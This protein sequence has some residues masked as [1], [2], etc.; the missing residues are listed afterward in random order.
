VKLTLTILKILGAAA[1]VALLLW[2]TWLTRLSS[3]PDV[4]LADRPAE[5]SQTQNQTQP[6][7]PA[8]QGNT[9]TVGVYFKDQDCY[10]RMMRAFSPGLEPLP[11]GLTPSRFENYPQGVKTHT[12]LP[13]D[14][15]LR[16]VNIFTRSPNVAGA[17]VGPLLAMLGLA[18]LVFWWWRSQI[19]HAWMALVLFAVS[20]IIAQATLLGRPDHQAL[21]IVALTIALS[22]ELALLNRVQRRPIPPDDQDAEGETLYGLPARL[23]QD[24]E[25]ASPFR[26]HAVLWQITGGL[27]WGLAFWTSL[28]EPLILLIILLVLT[29]AFLREGLTWHV[30]RW[31]L[32][33]FGILLVPALIDALPL[34]P[35]GAGPGQE[36]FANWAKTIPELRSQGLGILFSGFRGSVGALPD[37]VG[38]GIYLAP[39]L[40]LVGWMQRR[41]RLILVTGLLV[42]VLVVLSAIQ[43][44]WA[45]YAALIF[46]LTLPWQMKALPHAWLGAPVFLIPLFWPVATHWEMLF[47]PPPEQKQLLQNHRSEQVMIRRVSNTIAGEVPRDARAAQ[48]ILAPWWMSPSMAYW[49]GVPTVAGSSHQSLPGIADSFRFYLTSDPRE[50]AAILHE[51]RV[52]WVLAEDPQRILPMGMVFF[53]DELPTGP[54]TQRVVGA[55]GAPADPAQPQFTP[56]GQLARFEHSMATL[57]YHRPRQAPGFLV[58]HSDHFFFKL[59]RVDENVLNQYINRPPATKPRGA[60]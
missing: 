20:P 10:S 57:M 47:D 44:R 46:G 21:L 32:L 40:F 16:A 50:A 54:V 53:G 26:R 31:W 24:D 7:P 5:T 34:T 41:E 29:L 14:M 52:R 39:I 2:L 55:E 35:P 59:Y 56:S 3:A 33:G 42:L 51:R 60:R 9:A 36:F 30:R 43:L 13:M 18:W 19:P 15:A 1:G 25:H 22:S 37:W 8:A 48:S 27:A 11:P 6:Q 38:W 23:E 58:P 49:S 28:Y 45:F 17:F 4:F 12:T